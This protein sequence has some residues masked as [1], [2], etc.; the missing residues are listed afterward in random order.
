MED[1]CGGTAIYE[2]AGTK[3][4]MYSILD[5]NDCEKNVYKGHTS[6]IGHSEFIDAQSNEKVIL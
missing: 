4:K 3:S 6:N 1:E 2:F 5:A